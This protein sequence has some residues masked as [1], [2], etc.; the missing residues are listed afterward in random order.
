MW[1]RQHSWVSHLL[2]TFVGPEYLALK[3]ICGLNAAL[4]TNGRGGTEAERIARGAVIF[5]HA[6]MNLPAS[7]VEFLDAFHGSF[8]SKAWCGK[9]LPLV[10]LYLFARNDQK[11]TGLALKLLALA[12][13]C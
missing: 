13:S 4:D 10:H 12:K 2:L 6:I 7:A 5:Q 1:N 8:D 9:Q 3:R 11:D